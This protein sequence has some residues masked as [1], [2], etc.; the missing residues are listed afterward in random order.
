MDV[1]DTIKAAAD[2]AKESGNNELYKLIISI[3]DAYQELSDENK[4]LDAYIVSLQKERQKRDN[5]ILKGDCYYILKEND[6]LDGPYCP[7]CWDKEEE[8]NK[9]HI[10]KHANKNIA[11]CY[12]C[13][14]KTASF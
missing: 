10:V 4:K 3:K 6:E 13:Y 14:Y 1:Y 2:L 11:T 8:L 5:L 12:I 7:Y 9:M